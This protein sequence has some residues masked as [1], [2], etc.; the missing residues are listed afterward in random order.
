MPKRYAQVWIVGG[1]GGIELK[2]KAVELHISDDK[3]RVGTLMIGKVGIKWLRKGKRR[4]K[5]FE[6]TITWKTLDKA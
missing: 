3:G 6:K 5:G 2:T 1:K 4:N